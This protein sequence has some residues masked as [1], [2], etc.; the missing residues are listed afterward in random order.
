[1]AD[2]LSQVLT[3]GPGSFLAKQLGVPQPQPLRRYKAGEPALAGPLLIG[4]EGRVAEPLRAAHEV[5]ERNRLAR[6][7]PETQGRPLPRGQPALRLCRRQPRADSV[8]ARRGSPAEGLLREARCR[9]SAA[10]ACPRR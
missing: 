3:S 2:V 7:H 10:T 5:R 4:G 9:A 8:V 1:M 6:G